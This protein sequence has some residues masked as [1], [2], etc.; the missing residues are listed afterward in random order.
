METE[1]T[2]LLSKDDIL[3]ADDIKAETVGV[4]EWGGEVLVRPLSGRERDQYEADSYV[5]RNG[6]MEVDPRNARARLVVMCVVD[7]DG[8]PL[9]TRDDVAALGEKSAAALDRIFTAAAR[10]SGLSEADQKELEGNFGGE[11][12]TGSSTSSPNGSAQPSKVS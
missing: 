12:G 11:A 2:V 10:L 3:K 6:Q 9:F 8:K 7:G 5:Q 1:K 4:P